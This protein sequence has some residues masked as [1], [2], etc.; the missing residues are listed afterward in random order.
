MGNSFLDQLR[1]YLTD[2]KNPLL[3]FTLVCVGY[4]IIGVLTL[5]GVYFYTQH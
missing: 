2:V 3:F 5:L 1:E 4:F